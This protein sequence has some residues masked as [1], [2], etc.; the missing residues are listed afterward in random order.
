[1]AVAGL[2]LLD[3]GCPSAGREFSDSID[4]KVG[5]AREDRDEVVAERQA[6]AA[7]SF[8]DRNDGG[9]SWSSLFTSDV[10]PISAV[11]ERFP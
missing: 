4:R 2:R 9:D 8:D 11:M 7:T 5:Q 1:M 6:Q 3:P 10:Y